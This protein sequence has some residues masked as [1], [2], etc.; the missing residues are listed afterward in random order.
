[1]SPL[2]LG[3]EGY[4][5]GNDSQTKQQ[6]IIVDNIIG[7]KNVDLENIP[8]VLTLRKGDKNSSPALVSYRDPSKFIVQ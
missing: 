6:G 1:M 5:S 3:L 8:K 4:Q 2:G 7:S